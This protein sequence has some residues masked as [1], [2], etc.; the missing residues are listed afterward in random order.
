[1]SIKTIDEIYAAINPFP[2]M[3]SAKG[4]VRPVANLQIE[5][6]A[7][8]SLHLNWMKADSSREWDRNYE[9]FVGANADEAIGKA[10][11]FINSL[12]D[13]KTARLHE[14]LGQLG[15]VIDSGRSLGIEVDYLNPLTETMKRLSENI[16][17]HKRGAA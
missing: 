11:S 17:T 14:F 10:I 7:S 5:A 13:A 2:A 9:V 3:L 4:K 8:V 12:P 1:M 15:R 6:N 16:L